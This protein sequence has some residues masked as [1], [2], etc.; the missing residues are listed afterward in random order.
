MSKQF[1]CFPMELLK[2]N[3]ESPVIAIEELCLSTVYN[4]TG[5][6]PLWVTPDG[7]TINAAIILSHLIN[8]YEEGLNPD[9]YKVK[10][11][12]ALWPL[13]SMGNLAKLD[14]L[15]TYN[16]V[17]Y[18]HDVS[19]GQL[20]PH[21]ADPALFAEAG[22]ENFDPLRTI[23]IVLATLDLDKYLTD[24][25]P[26]HSHYTS[27]RS[28]LKKYRDLEAS[29]GWQHIPEGKT[30]RP[31]DEDNRL[32]LVRARLKK[33]G[34][35]A[36]D[37]V[38][39]ALFD[40][41]LKDAVI[42]FQRRYGLEQDGIIG[43]QTLTAMNIPPNELI[44]T[45]RVN[46][47]RWRWQAHD[48]GQRYII[49]NIAG[50]NLKAFDGETAELD[51]PVIVGKEQHQTPVFSDRIKYLDFNPFWNI[52]PTI[53]R[54]EDLPKLRKNPRYLVERNV[55]LFSSWQA[56]ASE[57]DSTA[58]DWANV[59]KSQMSTY[60]LR[61]DPGPWNALGKV[62]FVFP[63]HYSVYMHDTPTH[64]LFS[65]T[66][67]NFSH[68][69]I[70]VSN[71]LALAVF[72]LEGQD[73]GWDREAVEEVFQQESRKVIRLS[74]PLPVHITYQTTWVDKNGSINFNKDVYARDSKL[75]NALFSG[76]IDSTTKRNE[77]A[78][79]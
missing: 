47:A 59:S 32:L 73:G 63:N 44:D 74:S 49:V 3:H 56:N 57:L 10:E 52:T 2:K 79:D 58:I 72:A 5:G 60:L 46:M 27:L 67:R 42:S 48:L 37:S 13:R 40:D 36:K 23:E 33:T 24:L 55:R 54:N 65:R 31:G 18:I 19:H 28:A 62:K 8:S 38:T 34:E 41:D 12:L 61:Q 78:H 21:S 11:M 68:G 30:M 76:E 15:L 7:P 64:D 45:I 50:Y 29:G 70:R 9:N 51:F 66:T 4:G 1:V 77:L 26:S 43:I 25:P 17:K 22:D 35:L 16:L 20:K 6:Q 71:P 14:T 69:C 53:A 39:P 75:Y